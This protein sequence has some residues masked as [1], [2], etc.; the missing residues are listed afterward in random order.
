MQVSRIGS[1]AEWSD[2][3]LQVR[4][5]MPCA[6]VNFSG[7]SVHFHSP[8]TIPHV[9]AQRMFPL[10][11]D[12]DGNVGSNFSRNRVCGKTKIRRGWHIYVHASGYRFEIPIPVFPGI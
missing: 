3:F 10:F 2:S 8:T 11:L 4:A 12:Y 9:C 6:N 7:N 5:L 1:S